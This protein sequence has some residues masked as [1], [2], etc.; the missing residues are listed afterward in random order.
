MKRYTVVGL[1]FVVIWLAACAPTLMVQQKY[2]PSAGDKFRFQIDMKSPIPP[3]ALSIMRER[4][5]SELTRRNLLAS[6]DSKNYKVVQIE[7]NEYFMRHGAARQMG[8][9]FAGTDVISTA[10]AV[11]QEGS[12]VTF[13][14]FSVKSTNNTAWG[15]AKGLI[16]DHVDK[17]V[18]QLVGEK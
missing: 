12:A 4:M 18:G 5:T 6:A 16:E 2:Q 7:V 11:R 1:W 8:G 13:G 9:I 10:T 17:I 3:E 15:T 14:Q